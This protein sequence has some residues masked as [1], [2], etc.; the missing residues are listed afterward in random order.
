[1]CC[2][3]NVLRMVSKHRHWFLLPSSQDCTGLFIQPGRGRYGNFLH[4]SDALMTFQSYSKQKFGYCCVL[5]FWGGWGLPWGSAARVVASTLGCSTG[6]SG[7]AGTCGAGWGGCGFGWGGA[8]GCC[9]A[10]GARHVS[11]T[12]S[13][14]GLS[15]QS[16]ASREAWGRNMLQSQDTELKVSVSMIF[17]LFFYFKKKKL[18]N[19]HGWKVWQQQENIPGQILFLYRSLQ[20]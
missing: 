19:R 4:S 10:T 12:T 7:G 18:Q 14:V 15:L 1:M 2:R 9:S 16:W 20:L 13:D 3:H 5:F 17:F 6:F 8:A 11:L